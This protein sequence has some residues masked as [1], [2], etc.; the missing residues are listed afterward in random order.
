MNK[1]L[2]KFKNTS[3]LMNR[4]F[5]FQITENIGFVNDVRR[6]ILQ[7]GSVPGGLLSDNCSLKDSV[8]KIGIPVTSGLFMAMD[9]SRTYKTTNSSATMGDIYNQQSNLSQASSPVGRLPYSVAN[10]IQHTQETSS[11][12]YEGSSMNLF[13]KS[14]DG[15]FQGV[16]SSWRKLKSAFASQFK[17]GVVGAEVI[18]SS[19]NA[20]LNRQASYNAGSAR[21]DSLS[22]YGKSLTIQGSQIS[23]EQRIRSSSIHNQVVDDRNVSNGL[24][25][26]R[27]SGNRSVHMNHNSSTVGVP[28]LEG[29]QISNGIKSYSG[30]ASGRCSASNT[31]GGADAYLPG[32]SIPGIDFHNS[33]PVKTE[34]VSCVAG[35]SSVSQMLPLPK[36]FAGGQCSKDSN[37]TRNGLALHEKIMDTESFQALNISLFDT[38]ENTFLNGHIPDF[39]REC[40]DFDNK[41]AY[42]GTNGDL[43]NQYARSSSGNDLFD[44]FGMDFKNKFLG[45]SELDGDKHN[46]H[47]NTPTYSSIK[48]PESAFYS[49]NEGMSESGIFSAMGTDHLL[50]AVVS[51]AKFSTKQSSEDNLSCRTT[52]TKN[53]NASVLCS[54]SA[55]DHVTLSKYTGGEKCQLPDSLNKAKMVKSSSFK[56][57]C[58]MEN[59]GNCSQGTTVYGSQISSWVEQGN[60]MK[61]ESSVSAAYSKRPD[62]VG[63]SN[64]KR[65]KPGENPRPRPKDR[66][67]IQD[68]VKELREIVPSGAKVVALHS[69][70]MRLVL[71]RVS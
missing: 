17:D 63:K 1:N 28:F 9:P 23:T 14:H 39:V 36:G 57:G 18:P 59:S 15:P 24:S 53:S 70:T 40:Q 4:Y 48:D 6:L 3:W 52:M 42:S 46:M 44:I 25:T 66:Q 64:R 31:Y 19:S 65:L 68:R 49:E 43:E 27:L 62:E 8:E 20:C 22:G 11:L 71:E 69:S 37:I 35:Q 5:L 26:S 45:A 56:S 16:D 32:T 54:S 38:D 41:I 29:R 50:D 13:P 7:L 51:K 12:P 67:M 58:S 47:G 61:H 21:N 33:E 60:G 34:V 55:Y 10:Q 2:S 30:S